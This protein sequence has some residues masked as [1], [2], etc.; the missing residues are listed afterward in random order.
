MARLVIRGMSGILR[1]LF[2]DKVGKYGA[3]GM[4][5]FEVTRGKRFPVHVIKEKNVFFALHFFSKFHL[6]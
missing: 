2:L 5:N 4:Y 3:F 1:Y 6:S